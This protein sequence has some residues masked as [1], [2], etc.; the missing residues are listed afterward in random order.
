MFVGGA[1]GTVTI[2]VTMFI[3][4]FTAGFVAAMDEYDGWEY[5]DK[6]LAEEWP[7]VEKDIT[8]WFNDVEEEYK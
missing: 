3:L 2:A 1:T 6:W 8:D 5:L 4:T 7:K